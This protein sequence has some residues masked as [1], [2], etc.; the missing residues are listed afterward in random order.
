MQ[1]EQVAGVG[2]CD[3][4]QKLVILKCLDRS[5]S[6]AKSCALWPWNLESHGEPIFVVPHIIP[7]K[8]KWLNWLTVSGAGIH[9]IICIY[10]YIWYVS[11]W[12]CPRIARKK[13]KQKVPVFH[14][15]SLP[16]ALRSLPEQQKI[17]ETLPPET[18][19][20]A[21]DPVWF[22]FYHL[23]RIQTN[24]HKTHPIK[25]RKIIFQTSPFLPIPAVEF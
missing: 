15:L 23:L 4:A 13:P 11:R 17:T 6:L 5:R 25:K 16:T 19:N 22:N 8:G 24:Q 18:G 12:K 2:V 3:G 21:G 7:F 20:S 10:I 14:L 9:S 1:D